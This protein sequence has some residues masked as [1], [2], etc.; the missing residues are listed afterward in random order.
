MNDY[1]KTILEEMNISPNFAQWSVDLVQDGLTNHVVEI[2]CG[3]GRNLDALQKISKEL[4]ASDYN[5]KYLDEIEKRFPNMKN[6]TF[7]WNLSEP[8]KKKLHVDSFFCSNVIEHIYDDKVALMNI[9]RI[10]SIRKGVFIVPGRNSLHNEL[11]VSLGH[12]RRYDKEEFSNLLYECGFSVNKIFTFNKIGVVGWFV[13]GSMLRKKTLGES[14]MKI[15]NF[16]FPFIKLSDHYL[17]FHGLSIA[18]LVEKR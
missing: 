17:P 15:Y 12:Y 10:D 1:S 13:Q 16:I 14:N 7:Q 3:I 5:Q 2:G 9:A 11:D 4:F 6:N 8:L 18:A